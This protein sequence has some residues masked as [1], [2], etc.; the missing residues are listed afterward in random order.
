MASTLGMASGLLVLLVLAL[1][2]Y[3]HPGLASGQRARWA[4]FVALV[5]II[6]FVAFLLV[7]G[8]RR[9]GRTAEVERLPR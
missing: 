6:G 4:L 3:F 7:H 5:P 8:Y 2:V 1:R 9:Q